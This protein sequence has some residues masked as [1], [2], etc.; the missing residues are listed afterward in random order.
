M[1]ASIGTPRPRAQVIS[2]PD[3][4]SAVVNCPTW[5][6]PDVLY[7]WREWRMIRHACEGER[8]IKD[9]GDVYL[10]MLEGMEGD[11]YIAYLDRAT[12]YNFTGR[13]VTALAGTILRREPTVEGIPERLKTNFER[14]TKANQDFA[15]FS[16]IL[17]PEV[18]RMGRFGVLVDLPNVVTTE[19]KPYLTTYTA[20]NI[21]D[22][23]ETDVEGRT[24]LTNVVLRE[25]KLVK[26][27]DQSG[28]VV[29]RFVPQYRRLWLDFEAAGHPYRQAVYM[30][31]DGNDT[32]DISEAYRIGPV[33]TPL[34]RG[35]PL[36]YIPFR[37]FGALQSTA[38]VEKAPMQD[39]ARL[40]LSHYR[41]YAHLEHGRLFAGFPIYYVEAPMTG[42]DADIEFELGASKVWVTPAGAKPGLLELNGQGLK[43]LVDA[44]DQKE[45]QAAALG[46]RMMGVRSSASTESDNQLK[47]AER[48]EQAVLLNITRSID[49]GMTQVLRWWCAFQGVS[50]AD[51][52]K[53][54]VYY[55]KDFLFDLAGA[56]E[57]RAIQ[58]MYNDGIL[59]IEVLYDYFRK[60]SVVPDWM[61][62]EEFTD[63]LNKSGSFPNNADIMAQKEGYAN[64]QAQLTT[65]ENEKDRE[66]E[67]ELADKQQQ[68][69]VKV[70]K[71]KPPTP[72]PGAPGQ[73]AKKPAP[74]A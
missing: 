56:R 31:S 39:I 63:L 1:P 71:A 17:V 35:E 62:L 72:P 64:A 42:D 16:G 30:A 67:L 38:E 11:E 40:N 21:V 19:P 23:T 14:L 24:T 6:H 74:K 9:W 54:W 27:T 36:D 34:I 58:A 15:I 48:N 52:A 7:W 26:V 53:I 66:L 12:F 73:P 37:F 51:Q 43:F 18:I 13:T 4:R 46:G 3:L 59:P 55:N 70:A 45:Q 2:N 44:L 61:S 60:A 29:Q 5:A 65:E 33:V 8:T 32:P 22:W 20:E 68:T 57:F 10:P 25:I 41:S 69:A 49:A 50:E 47:L 28:N